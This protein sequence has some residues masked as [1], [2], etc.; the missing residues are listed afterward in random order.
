MELSKIRTVP[1]RVLDG[2]DIEPWHWSCSP[3]C[4]WYQATITTDLVINPNKEA[5]ISI[6]LAKDLVKNGIIVLTSFVDED[7]INS[8]QRNRVMLILGTNTSPIKIESNTLL[9]IA[10]IAINN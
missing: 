10:N 6:N 1:I 9:G 8:H 4:N 7:Q 3:T 5:V 2:F